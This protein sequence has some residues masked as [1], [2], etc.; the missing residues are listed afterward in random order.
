MS[1]WTTVQY[2]TSRIYEAECTTDG[3]DC[4]AASGSMRS[5][6]DVG[7]WTKAHCQETGHTRFLRIFSD[8]AIVQCEGHP[9]SPRSAARTLQ[10]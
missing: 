7:A 9:L 2:P 1:A 4:T 10:Q 3:L 8:H 5:I 6:G